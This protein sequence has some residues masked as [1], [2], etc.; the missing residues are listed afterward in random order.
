M[1]RYLGTGGKWLSCLAVLSFLAALFPRPLTETQQMEKTKGR[2][3]WEIHNKR[4]VAILF[5]VTW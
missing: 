5:A 4:S 3:F 2:I 1:R